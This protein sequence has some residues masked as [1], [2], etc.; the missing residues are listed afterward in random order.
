MSE[1]TPDAADEPMV[2][3][4]NI[5][6]SYHST[7]VI[8]DISF[9]V[10]RGEVV[11]LIG[12]S[13]AGKSTL[14]RCI[15][16]LEVPD[17]GYILVDSDLVGYRESGD[18]FV[19]A[20][21]A[22]AARSRA[23]VGMVFQRFNLF[24]HLTATENV[25]LAPREVLGMSKAESTKLAHELLGRVGLSHRVNNYPSQLSGGEQQRVA[26][27]R[28]LAMNPKVML[29]DEATSALDPELVGDV[30]A[31]IQDLADEG[32]TMIMV[33]HEMEFAREVSSRV[34]F[35]ADGGIVEEGTPEQIFGDPQHERTRSF[36]SRVQRAA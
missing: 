32:M 29:F 25:T 18:D 11:S 8:K 22:Q 4:H 3:V 31:V 20:T 12:P 23:T 17:S 19:E 7:P 30:L 9:E 5:T 36:L 34:L 14:L 2:Y 24:Q 28:A 27:A 1:A 16:H 35:L 6:K 21:D 26:I 15:N 33:T 13:G 10:A